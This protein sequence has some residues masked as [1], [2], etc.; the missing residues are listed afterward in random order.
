MDMSAAYAKGAGIA[1][2]DA[3][4]SYDRFH[5]IAMAI[6]AMADVRRE[7]F[8]TEPEEVAQTLLSVG[9]CPQ[10]DRPSTCSS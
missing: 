2:P 7:E 3:A 1:L 5:V 10:P 6:Q 8:R 9:A 4:I